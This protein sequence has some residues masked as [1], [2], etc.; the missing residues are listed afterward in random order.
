MIL[1]LNKILKNLGYL[2]IVVSPL[3]VYQ[4]DFPVFNLTLFRL[5]F[6]LL[7]ILF[8]LKV[9]ITSKIKFHKNLYILLIFLIFSLAIGSAQ[10]NMH[11]NYSIPFIRNEII[12]ILI[13]FIFFNIYEKEDLKY[14]LKAF[15]ISL[16]FPLLFSIYTYLYFISNGKILDEYPLVN[17]FSIFV[18]H[19]ADYKRFSSYGVPRLTIPYAKP[20]FLALNVS[21]GLIIL[22][23][24]IFKFNLSNSFREKSLFLSFL[25]IVVGALTKTI[26]LSVIVTFFLYFLYKIKV[27]KFIKVKINLKSVVLIIVGLALILILIP[28]EI[29]TALG[30]RLAKSF[31]NIEEDRHLLLIYEAFNFWLK[32]IKTFFIGIGIANNPFNGKYTFL[33]PDSFLNIYLTIL[34]Q[35]GILGFFFTFMFY[36]YILIELYR[37][38][39]RERNWI[40]YV[41]FF[42]FINFLLAGFFYELRLALGVWFILA[43]CVV[44]LTNNINTKSNEII[45]CNTCI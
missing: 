31:G 22:Y 16:I 45:N 14:L 9:L 1:N 5:F 30:K 32:D 36:I 25:I 3:E 43:I 35:R 19:S 38:L 6:I 18:S 10:A 29:Y 41:L 17:R 12:G 21:F 37:K 7:V 11:N 20:P 2:C 24:R 8:I 42:C 4:I 26:Y 13:I 34:A 40:S 27:E 44:Y 28:S 15:I 23:F 33:P 39:E